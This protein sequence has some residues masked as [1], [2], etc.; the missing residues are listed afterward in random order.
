MT[1]TTMETDPILC[2]LQCLGLSRSRAK[3][4]L[5]EA[6]A[7]NPH[8]SPIKLAAGIASA[9]NSHRPFEAPPAKPVR[10]RRPRRTK[11][12]LEP[13]DLRTIVARGREAGLSAY[14]ALLKAGVIKP[15]L[16]DFPL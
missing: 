9:M 11:P 7:A 3:S 14:D 2:A 10:R 8:L 15:P 4:L 5:A 16:E 6:Q 12:P 1:S 13:G